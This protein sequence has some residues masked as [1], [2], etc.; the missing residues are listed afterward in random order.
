[1]IVHAMQPSC[2]I[3]RTRVI[4]DRERSRLNKR[5]MQSQRETKTQWSRLKIST[6]HLRR[7]CTYRLRGVNAVVDW[8]IWVAILVLSV[9]IDRAWTAAAVHLR[10][11]A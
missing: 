6:Q 1:M 10:R 2:E 4:S 5:K 7:E 11:L 8:L 3:K 9:V